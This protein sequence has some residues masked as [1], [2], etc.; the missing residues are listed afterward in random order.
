MEVFD[1]IRFNRFIAGWV[2]I[3][4]FLFT[5]YRQ[6]PMEVPNYEE[7]E[8]TDTV[9]QLQKRQIAKW[10][11]SAE[12]FVTLQTLNSRDSCLHSHLHPAMSVFLVNLQ[13]ICFTLR[14]NQATL[15]IKLLI[16]RNPT[17]RLD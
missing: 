13:Y 10:K 5:L 15:T 16:L 8:S 14:R 9:F 7:K 4:L 3:S 1:E 11:Q 12:R 17:P 6:R 2:S